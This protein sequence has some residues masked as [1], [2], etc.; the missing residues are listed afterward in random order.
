MTKCSFCAG[1]VPEGRGKTF[2]K[3][4]GKIFHFCN[5]KCQN[6]WKLK[7]QGKKT[8]WTQAYRDRKTKVGK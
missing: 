6:N 1:K 7:R 3:N 4:D 8:K 2:F 5:S